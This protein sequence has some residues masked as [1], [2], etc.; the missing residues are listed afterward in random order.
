MSHLRVLIVEDHPLMADALRV[1][2]Q[3]LARQMVCIHAHS[4]QQGLLCLQQPQGF[5]LV[6]LDLNLPD[7][8]GIDTLHAFCRV[9]TTGPMVVVTS[10]DDDEVDQACLANNVTLIHKTCSSSKMEAALMQVFTKTISSAQLPLETHHVSEAEPHLIDRLS[11]KQ[12]HVLA[13]L[14]QGQGSRAIA[15]KL[16]LSDATVRS[17]MTE[18]YLRLGVKNRTQASTLYLL[19][20]Q[21]RGIGHD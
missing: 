12:R 13:L 17:H 15:D 14:A 3:I 4:L 10:L 7:S 1:R 9:R 2:L 8:Q 6:L 11:N 16:H 20:T 18:I 21:Q 19:W 5:A